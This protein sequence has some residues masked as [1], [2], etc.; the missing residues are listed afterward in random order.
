[1]GPIIRQMIARQLQADDSRPKK[2]QASK[3]S[4]YVRKHKSRVTFNTVS[5]N[6]VLQAELKWSSRTC[7]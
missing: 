6:K 7:R 2:G 1:M 3:S 5:R 4:Y